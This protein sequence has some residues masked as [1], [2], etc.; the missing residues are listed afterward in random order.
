[1]SKDGLDV[2][3]GQLPTNTRLFLAR[4]GRCHLPLGGNVTRSSCIALNNIGTTFSLDRRIVIL[5]SADVL[6]SVS[7]DETDGVQTYSAC[8]HWPDES[9]ITETVAKSSHKV[10]LENDHITSILHAYKH[11]SMS[12]CSTAEPRNEPINK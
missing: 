6:R 1:M 11:R 10:N 12:L 7:A 2:H 8:T 4:L 9:G 3:V 5:R